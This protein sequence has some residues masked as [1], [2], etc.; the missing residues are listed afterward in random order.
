[1]KLRNQVNA[2]DEMRTGTDIVFAKIALELS[3]WFI[4]TMKRESTQDNILKLSSSN[5]HTKLAILLEYIERNNLVFFNTSSYFTKIKQNRNYRQTQ[6][7]IKLW[8]Q[9]KSK[10][11]CYTT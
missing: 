8:Y 3:D 6:N 7:P 5:F 10:I 4:T 2:F 1:M 9:F 11:D